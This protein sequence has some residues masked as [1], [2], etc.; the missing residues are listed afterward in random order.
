[1]TVKV[2]GQTAGTISVAAAAW[3]D[4]PVPG[5]WAA[6]SHQVSIAFVGD[7]RDNACDRNLRVDKLTFNAVPTPVVVSGVEAESM[8]LTPG[9]GQAFTDASASGGAGL[10]VWSNGTATTTVTGAAGQLVI[11][12]RGDLCAGA[13]SMSVAID[14]QPAGTVSVD[15][16]A[17]QDYPVAW[18]AGTHRVDVAFTND[19]VTA[20]CD[21][22]LRLDMLSVATGSPAPAPAP[23]PTPASGNSFA[24]A[25]E[26]VDPQSPAAQAA[27]AR[28]SWDPAGAAALD[29]V[30][31][32][33]KADWYGDWVATSAMASTVSARVS[34]ETAAGDL[35]V[36]VAYAIPHRDCGSYSAGG[37]ANADA[38]RS[39][40]GQLAAGIGGRKAVVILEPDALP[41]LDCLSGA[42]QNERT[43]LI[44]GAVN[45]L[46]AQS[47]TSVY[48]DAGL[49]GWQSESVMASRLNAAGVAKARGFS[50]NVSNFNTNAANE[51]Y[52][53]N[54]SSM[55]GGKHFVV[56][57]SRNGLGLGNTWC[58]P[59]G[60]ALGAKFTTVTGDALADAF[61]WI[62]GPGESDGTCNGGPSAGQFWTDY[63][64]GLGQRA[65]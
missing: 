49:P 21:R 11:R 22:N 64:I 50:L 54:L 24:G 40:I 46:T 28:R 43:A 56:D 5:T 23:A 18:P 10:L 53:D 15:A 44:A 6:G 51:T 60:R 27:Q 47:S 1:M 31:A 55:V 62:K 29:K 58:N 25:R 13:P 26:Y 14:G 2:D 42:D 39:W 48:I 3:Q 57:T 20:T 36:L 16:Q 17:W 8:A 34:T 63:A 45:T 37:V 61:T 12:A 52:G 65:S 59:P 41:Q 33:S 19:Y 32:G 30:A 35:P 38:Y 9:A 4:Y 7:Y